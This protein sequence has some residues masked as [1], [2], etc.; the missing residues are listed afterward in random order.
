MARQNIQQNF[1]SSVGFK[2]SINR[3][4]NT[5]FY[6]QSANVPGLDGGVSE[7]PNPFKTIY[8]AG[9][10]LTFND[11]VVT[12]RMDSKLETYEEIADWMFGLYYPE[13]FEQQQELIDGAGLYSDA[14][15]TILTPKGNPMLDF[16]FKDIFPYNLGELQMD[17][18]A[19]DVDYLTC[20]M[21][22]KVNGFE[23][24]NHLTR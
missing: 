2:F 6:I 23:L 11:L 21:T 14:T 16:K 19:S 5:T 18:T 12:V 8:R 7:Q 22:F 10:K 24:I 20:T 9:D 17:T 15:L 1:L 4:P 13:S 3:L